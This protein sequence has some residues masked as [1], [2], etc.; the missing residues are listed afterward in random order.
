MK[1]NQV[2]TVFSLVCIISLFPASLT[3]QD[4]EKAPKVNKELKQ[5]MKELPSDIQLQVLRYA[6]RQKAAYTAA[7]VKRDEM[8]NTTVKKVEATKPVQVAPASKVEVEKKASPSPKKAVELKPA[9]SANS[10][11]SATPPSAAPAAPAK[12][13]YMRIA[14]SMAP[15]SIEWAEESFD[16]GKVNEG[17]KP[18]HIY[19]FKNTG[20][21]PLKITRVKPSCGCT[22]P[23]W[24]KEEIAPGEEGFVEV[25]YNSKNRPGMANKSITVTGNFEQRNKVLRFKVD[26]IKAE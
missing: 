13:E 26:V 3:A 15:T 8:L 17:E 5:V 6:E 21:N 19:R 11:Y 2:I 16:F 22:T 10:G 24:S 1:I 7:K 12:P 4:K 23:S 14:E 9:G 20:S 18:S 25:S